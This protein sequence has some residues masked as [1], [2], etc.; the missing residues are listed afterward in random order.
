MM[1]FC[2]RPKVAS[3]ISCPKAPSQGL[4]WPVWAIHT[5]HI[6]KKSLALD[7]LIGFW[8]AASGPLQCLPGKSVFVHPG[9]RDTSDRGWR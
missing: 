2:L 7:F 9:F 3:N 6:P 8:E 1:V 5:P 4:T